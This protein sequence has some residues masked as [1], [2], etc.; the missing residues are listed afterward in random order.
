MRIGI[1]MKIIKKLLSRFKDE[2]LKD[3]LVYTLFFSVLSSIIIYVFAFYN[4]SFIWSVDG[5][6][7]HYITLNY[8][9]N[10]LINYKLTGIFNTFTWNIGY[11]LDM[12]ANLAYYSFGDLFSY[13]SIYVKESNLEQYFNISVILRMWLTGISFIIFCKYKNFK[14]HG[15]I[16]GSLIYTFT[17]SNYILFFR[18]PFMYNAAIVLPLF[19]IGI[20]KSIR[21]HY[22][23]PLII[24]SFLVFMAGFYFAYMICILMIIYGIL[25]AI[26]T[27]KKEVHKTIYSLLA[28][29]IMG[30]IGLMLASIVIIPSISE[31]LDSS[32]IFSRDNYIYNLN[33]YHNIFQ[34]LILNSNYKNNTL[35]GI[36]LFSIFILP[37]FIREKKDIPAI[38]VIIIILLGIL[39]PKVGSFLVGMSYPLNRYTFILCFF[40]AY[41]VAATINEDFYIDMKRIKYG[42]LGITI[43][44]LV[45]FIVESE[46]K[47]DF[48]SNL[49]VLAFMVYIYSH[50]FERFKIIRNTLLII[51]L[52]L[53]IGFSI[54]SC[55]D[56][57][58]NN[59]VNG[60]TITGVDFTY[61]TNNNT[62]ANFKDALLYLKEKDKSFYLIGKYPYNFNMA[63]LSLYNNYQSMSYY[64]SINSN[65]YNILATDLKNNQY[66]ISYEIEEFNYRTRITSLLGNKYFITDN[67][68]YV[69][70]GYK[71]IK[72]IKNNNKTTYIYE[73]NN[74][75]KFGIIYQDYIKEED[76]DKLS[77][78]EKEV[79]LLK[80]TV[81]DKDHTYHFA[82]FKDY[83]KH[84]DK[85]IK[86]YNNKVLFN[87]KELKKK[88][89]KI[90]D[91]DS[92]Y[93][94][95][96]TDKI[97]NREIYIK[98]NGLKYET[99]SINEILNRNLNKL[100]PTN[101]NNYLHKSKWDNNLYDY[102]VQAS[103]GGHYVSKKYRDY[104]TDPYYYEID[105]SYMN[106]GYYEKFNGTIKLKFN[107]VGTYTYD[108]IEIIAV[109]FDDY[110]SDV[111]ELN[112]SNFDIIEY[113]D[114][115]MKASTKTS[116]DGILQL[117]TNYLDGFKV[118]VDGKEV[119]KLRSNKY[120]I[121]IYLAKGDHTI[122]LKYETPYVREGLK[123][124]KIGIYLTI[125]IFLFDCEKMM[126]KR[127]F[128]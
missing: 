12:F 121:G 49:F 116:R 71:L 68:R 72:E 22:Y 10:L 115:Y 20:E 118:F 23:L 82:Y 126:K 76:Y 18:H 85:N 35:I 91:K 51:C 52:S 44:S 123:I 100:N 61:D 30:C 114:G 29:L 25:F 5:L 41:G 97:K 90:T 59:F 92:E 21:D 104:I 17:A 96:K 63:N 40:L 107:K 81:L 50:K 83:K 120:F 88:E 94:E 103:S 45:L 77:E 109:N 64:F 74:Y 102:T 31:Y 38:S 55:Y 122:E 47:L 73:N 117:N 14:G 79:G 89:I 108:S 99:E 7:Q 54:Y 11:G 57:N 33:Y 62:I 125:I 46:L 16:L 127:Y 95:V 98:I 101:I 53:G 113:K 87:N 8:F 70:Y 19:T 106:L 56:S 28:C 93:L 67:K 2:Y 34:S 110:S 4:R 84:I 43:Y 39:I 80:T 15:V 27:Y 112:K 86:K 6:S 36:S 26:V 65:N 124:T 58:Y 13:L 3:I 111:K 105:S 48:I 9:R 1:I 66:D 119:E 24:T 42:F 78:S 128:S 37:I 69:P 60:H 75:I 32:R